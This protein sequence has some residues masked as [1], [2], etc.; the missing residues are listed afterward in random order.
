MAMR[1]ITFIYSPGRV[2]RLESVR[3]G[4]S[5]SDFFYGAVE[6]EKQGM[7]VRIIEADPST[8]P[9][10]PSALLNFVGP[11]G[12]VKLDGN[13]TQA[14]WNILPQAK[15][16]DVVVGTTGAHAFALALLK[17]LRRHS[18]PVVGIQC[19]LLNHPINAWRR[20]SSVALLRRMESMLFGE[21]ERQP[22]LDAYPG[23]HGHLHVNQFGVDTQFWKPGPARE[24]GYVLAVGNDGR[25]DYG[26][27]MEAARRVDIPFVVVTGHDLP[28][29]PPHVRHLKGSFS[30]GVSDLDLRDLFRGAACVVTPLKPTLQP[31]GQS[32]TLQAMAC[33]RPVI[34]TDT[35]GLWSRETL[36][37]R[38]TISL[39]PPEDAGTLADRIRE[40]L[41][42]KSFAGRLGEF[43]RE[44]VCRHA[45]IQQFAERLERICR[46]AGEK[47]KEA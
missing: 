19:G 42:D 16:S 30:N 39:T 2:K 24:S 40:I 32:V 18:L 31:S 35:Q 44:A 27:L 29:R 34:L 15:T 43:A 22:V 21:G 6:L 41:S 14:V 10:W 9:H 8:P 28:R 45:T 20:R 3:R 26:T 25:R 23:I 38:E 4:E 36:R 33:G 46:R 13:I 7:E 47:E 5:P 12:P 37:D 1:S 11:N 17:W